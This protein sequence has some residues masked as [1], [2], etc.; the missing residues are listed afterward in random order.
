MEL[1]II[2]YNMAHLSPSVIAAAALCLSMKLL[3][4]GNWVS[5]SFSLCV[6]ALCLSMRLLDQGN[7]VSLFLSLCSASP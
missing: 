4:Q 7:W 3:D 6:C 1:T 5:L 2:D